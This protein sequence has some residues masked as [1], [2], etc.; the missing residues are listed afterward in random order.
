MT[1]Q[2]P[3]PQIDIHPF[4]KLPVSIARQQQIIDAINASLKLKPRQGFCFTG[5]PGTGKT[6]LMK[7]IQRAIVKAYA[8]GAIRPIVPRIFTLSEW[9]TAR[10]AKV[11]GDAAPLVNAVSAERIREIAYWNK[12][13]SQS[14]PSV[15][16]AMSG[17]VFPFETFHLFIDEFDTQPT[18]SDF[19]QSGLQELVNTLYENAPR[20]VPGN[21]QDFCQLV[22]A[23]NK[24]RAEFRSAYGD[25]VF[26]RIAEMCVVVDFDKDVDD[27]K[28]IIE[29]ESEKSSLVP[30]AIDKALEAIL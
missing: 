27:P 20:I 11:R 8:G 28:G 24:S 19:A 18:V 16:E 2:F 29:P 5:R 7:S 6:Y 13:K 30:D 12:S 23:M 14:I 17:S 3:I 21:D 15:Q 1:I 26:R 22:V 25:H 4:S 9:Q 10:V